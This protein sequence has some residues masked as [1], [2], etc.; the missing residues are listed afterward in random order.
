MH[1][2]EKRTEGGQSPLSA[3]MQ[4]QRVS[5]PTTDRAGQEPQCSC[6][7][8]SPLLNGAA[9]VLV[10][11]QQGNAWGLEGDFRPRARVCVY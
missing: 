8:C 1:T 2:G 9:L 5:L 4:G 10:K 7:R 11:Y 6:L 3:T